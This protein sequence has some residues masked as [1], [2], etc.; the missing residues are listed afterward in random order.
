MTEEMYM[1]TAKLSSNY[2]W[3]K[4]F[5]DENHNSIVMSDDA[6]VDIDTCGE[7]VKYCIFHLFDIGNEAHQL[8]KKTFA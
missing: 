4:F 7:E 1:F 6:F 8:Y 5:V 3:A 2:R